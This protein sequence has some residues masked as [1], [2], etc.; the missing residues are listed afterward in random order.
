[1]NQYHTH[2]NHIAHESGK[3]TLVNSDIQYEFVTVLPLWELI[4]L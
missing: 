4:I 1:M 2:T 3:M